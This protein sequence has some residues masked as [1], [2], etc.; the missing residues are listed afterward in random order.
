MTNPLVIVYERDIYIRSIHRNTITVT[1]NLDLRR[2][3]GHEH[4]P[5]RQQSFCDLRQCF[6]RAETGLGRIQ[7]CS[8]GGSINRISSQMWNVPDKVNVPILTYILWL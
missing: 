8:N 3:R 6:D 1:T 5:S 2:N 7:E 4:F